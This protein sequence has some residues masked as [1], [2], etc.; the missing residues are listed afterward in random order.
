MNKART[1]VTGVAAVVAV[2]AIGACSNSGT[3]DAA[4]SSAPSTVQSSTAAPAAAHNQADMMFARMMIP[5]H[6]QAIEMSDMILAKQGI[7]P[8]VVDLA[9]QIKAAQ[10]PE[11]DTMQGWLNQWGMPGMPGMDNMPGMN[12]TSSSA[13]SDHGGM[14]GSDTA[15][16][17]PTTMPMPGMPA[18][19]DMPGMDGMMSPAD[20]QALQNAQG[21]E[22]SKLYLTQMIKHHQGAIT[23]AQNEIKDGQ[24][25]DAIAL[26]TS[27]ATSQQKEIDTMNQI[28]SSL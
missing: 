23:M 7:D 8:R 12:G 10:G 24:S 6:R 9:K 22:A 18:M 25:A 5:H 4:A 17:S 28:L 26:A 2:A 14:H 3:K 13:P 27:I 20:M 19:G 16:A 15:T 11:I 1:V 21:V